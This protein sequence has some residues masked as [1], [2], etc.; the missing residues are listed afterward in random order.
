MQH[1]ITLAL[2]GRASA[3]ELARKSLDGSAERDLLPHEAADWPT[4]A[5][6]SSAYPSS[7]PAHQH[8]GQTTHREPLNSANY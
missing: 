8:G 2:S 4:A 7:S 6:H 3:V 1:S 5:D